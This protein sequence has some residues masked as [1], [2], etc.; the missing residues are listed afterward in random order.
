MAK[1]KPFV[2]QLLDAMDGSDLT[3]NER[4]VLMAQFKFG[5]HAN[6]RD[7]FASEQRIAEYAGISIATVRRAR[8]ALR[9]K[10]WLVEKE[11]GH[12]ITGQKMAPIYWVTIPEFR[13]PTPKPKRAARNPAGRNQWIKPEVTRDLLPE[14]KQTKKTSPPEVTGDHPS[15][16]PFRGSNEPSEY[17]GGTSGEP[18]ET[19]GS[20]DAD[21]D[22]AGHKEMPSNNNEPVEDDLYITGLDLVGSDPGEPALQSPPSWFAAEDAAYGASLEK[23][24]DPSPPADDELDRSYVRVPPEG[25]SCSP[26]CDRPNHVSNCP[27]DPWAAGKK[28][29]MSGDLPP[30]PMLTFEAQ[31]PW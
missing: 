20:A 25:Q 17:V 14:V 29:D 16:L 22:V 23:Q 11:R 5:D 2:I 24:P 28:S 9:T 19:S 18:S 3:S 1:S 8:K 10:K 6:G 26:A 13:P 27:N 31:P 15:G 4:S 30:A 7:S 12:A 21:R